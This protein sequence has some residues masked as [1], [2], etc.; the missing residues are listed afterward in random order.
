MSTKRRMAIAAIAAAAMLL[1]GGGATA[2]ASQKATAA[3]PRTTAATGFTWHPL[4]LIDGATAWSPTS[5]GT[6]AYAVRDGVL[7]LKGIVREPGSIGAFTQL[8]VGARPSHYLWMNCF[9]LSRNVAC[10]LEI[11]P[12]GFI[13]AHTS[14][15]TPRASLA[16]ISFPLSS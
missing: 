1:A 16:G 15:G 13:A 12:D 9:N 8:P 5:Y 10:S 7:Y 4:H 11:G 2:L 3:T 6:P 14:T